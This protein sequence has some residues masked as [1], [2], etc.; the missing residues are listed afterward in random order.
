MKI[1]KSLV[2]V[3]AMAAMVAGAT[4]SVFTSSASVTGNTFATGTLEIRIDGQASI[5]GFTVA[6]AVPGTCQTGQFTLENYGPP[7][8]GGPS[9][10]PAK[11]LTMSAVKTGGD[12]NLYNALTIH[13]TKSAGS[14]EDIWNSDLYSLTNRDALMSWYHP[15]GLIAGSSETINYEVCL[16][17]SAGNSLQGLSTTFDFVANASSS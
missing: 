15:G 1:L 7:Y 3:I 17:L 10:V 2:V 11:T 4:S 9:T 12:L 6:N 13:M 16:P 8:F 5:P 14:S